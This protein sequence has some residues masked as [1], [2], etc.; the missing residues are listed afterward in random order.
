MLKRSDHPVERQR[1][2]G[3]KKE[4]GSVLSSLIIHFRQLATNYLPFSSICPSHDRKANVWQ[5]HRWVGNWS[6]MYGKL[7]EFNVWWWRLQGETK[8]ED[9]FSKIIYALSSELQT[10]TSI[11]FVILTT[12]GSF[13]R[14]DGLGAF[15]CS[16]GATLQSRWPHQR[17]GGLSD[18]EATCYLIAGL[19][20]CSGVVSEFHTK[21]P[22]WGTKTKKKESHWDGP[23]NKAA[24]R[25][26][27]QTVASTNEESWTKKSYSTLN[28]CE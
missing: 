5:A 18:N 9:N 27:F 28:N 12:C 13:R 2:G 14:T 26:F 20:N 17:R 15:L 1:R 6:L 3:G 11:T 10:Q 7:A 21:Q 23:C 4:S 22:K 16:K 8:E 19:L 24:K 25:W